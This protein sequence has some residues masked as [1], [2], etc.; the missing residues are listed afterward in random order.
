ME[1]DYSSKIENLSLLLVMTDEKDPLGREIVLSLIAEIQQELAGRPERLRLHDACAFVFTQ[2]PTISDSEFFQLLQNFASQA[3]TYLTNP[4]GAA[5]PNE[6]SSAPSDDLALNIDPRFVADFVEKHTVGLQE[7]EGKIVTF[8]FE[9]KKLPPEEYRPAAEQLTRYTKS[10]LHNIKGDAG[11]VG[12]MGIERATHHVESGIE[13]HELTT[14]LEPLLV[15]RNWVNECML[16]LVQGKDPSVSSRAFVRSFDQL[17]QDGPI[18]RLENVAEQPISPAPTGNPAACAANSDRPSELGTYT[19][20]ADAQLL[21]EFAT[22]V[23]DHLGNVEGII[24]ESEGRYE[25]ASVDAIFRCVHSVKGTSGY[26][27]LEEMQ[28]TS[29]ILENILDEVRS[30]KRVFDPPLT[31]LVLTF[32]DMQRNLMTAAKNA[33]AKDSV[34]TRSQEAADYLVALNAYASGVTPTSIVTTNQDLPPAAIVTHEIAASPVA[35]ASKP[36]EARESAQKPVAKP[37]DS[38][39]NR[40]RLDVKTYVKVDTKRLDQL[41]DAIGEMTIYSSILISHCRNQLTSD[42]EVNRTS[43]QVEKFARE[44]QDIGMSMR[45]D[46]IKGLFQ[47]MSRLVWD[48]SKKLGKEIDF[49][50]EGEDTELDRNLIEKLADPLMHMIR[51]ALDHGVEMPDERERMGK[52]RVGR[53]ELAAFHAGGSIHI[54]IRDDGKGI[55]PE[56]LLRKAREKGIIGESDKLNEQDT[57]QLIFAPGF[58]TAAVVTDVSGRG[59][60]MDVVKRNIESM[61]G[62]VHIESVIDQGTTFTI[63]LPLTLAI[64]DGIEIS[65]GSER[66]IFPSLSII[67]FVRPTEKMLSTT[68][69]SAEI[70]HFRGRFL[71]L[72]R[73]GELYGIPDACNIATDAT[74][75]V[76][77]NGGQQAAFLAD[78]VVGKITTVIKGLGPMFDQGQGLAGC[79]IMSNGQAALILDVRSLIHFARGHATGKAKPT[80]LPRFAQPDDFAPNIH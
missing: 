2:Q 14:M 58:S 25:N 39:G 33:V 43:H 6:C 19:I 55:N 52:S 36:G 51:N 61:R 79:A 8:Q 77:E 49:Q 64:L 48:T 80:V 37:T 54:R 38:E 11:A 7:L 74:V 32:I 62:A 9:I 46:P 41:I 63:A 66:L 53:V 40:E 20:Q 21:S 22:E 71:P 78:T 1:N 16:A 13:T 60:G 15:Y 57:F 68:L 27:A 35:A 34:V 47:K 12:L 23:E 28:Q 67:E 76:V 50:M 73:L 10:Y 59:V 3:Q 42:A 29:H 70:F 75:V 45:L 24:L 69:D 30:G 65:V 72:Y 17:F 44:L 4:V 26:F 31:Q 5:F 56:V 18:I